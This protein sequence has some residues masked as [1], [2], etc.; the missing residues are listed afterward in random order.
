MSVTPEFLAAVS[1][2]TGVPAQFLAGDTAADVWASA[3]TATEWR[4][5]PAVAPVRA[6]P[7]GSL[8][9]LPKRLPRKAFLTDHDPQLARRPL[10]APL[11]VTLFL[12]CVLDI[13]RPARPL[14]KQVIL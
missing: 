12:A 14:L 7:T 10:D 5:A 1:E 11:A 8:G 9:H 4:H 2:H 6:L 13:F 3:R